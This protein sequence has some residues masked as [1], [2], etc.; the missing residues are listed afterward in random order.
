MTRSSSRPPTPTRRARSPTS[1]RDAGVDDRARA[2]ARRRRPTSRRPA[3]RS[4]T[5]PGSRP[6]RS[7]RPPGCPR[8]P[9]TPASRSTRSAARPACARR[10]YA[11][12]DATYADNV[13]A[14][15]RAAARRRPRAAHRAVRHRCARARWPDGREVAAFGDGRGHDRR[16]EPRGERGFG[17]DPV[18]VPDEGDGRRSPR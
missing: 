15:A 9:T 3:P 7:A 11:G 17:Y 1:S 18:F 4:R 8:S 13:R 12:E 10:G 14:A 16:R 5:T 6:S 2:P